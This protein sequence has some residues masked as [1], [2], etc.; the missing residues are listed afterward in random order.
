MSELNTENGVCGTSLDFEL[1]RKSPLVSLAPVSG[2]LLKRFGRAEGGNIAMMFSLMSVVVVSMVGAA[3]DYGR[4]LHAR[5]QTQTALDSAVLAAGRTLQTTYGNATQSLEA[6][7]SYYAQMKSKIA[8]NDTVTFISTKANT[9]IEANGNAY[10]KTPFLSIIG[11]NELPLLYIADAKHS[12]ATIAQ[13]GNNGSSVEIGLMLDTTGSMSGQK[14]IDMK[15]AAK[16]LVDIVIWEDQSK[17]TSRIALAPFANT[18]NVGDYF[19]AVTGQNPNLVTH[20]EQQQTGTTNTYTY[21]PNCY[22]NSGNLKNSCK[23]K[24]QYITGT[25]PIYTTVTIVDNT[26]KA[27]CVVERTGA[28]EFTGAVPGAGTWITSWNDAIAT[29]YANRTALASAGA[30]N[31]GDFD[32]ASDAAKT[33]C[34]EASTIV[35]LTSDKTLLK[36]TID[37]FVAD[38]A[39]AGALGSAWAWYLIEPDWG[40][41]FTGSA[42]PESYAKMSQLGASGQ[43]LLQKIAIL[44]TDGA[45]NTHQGVQYGDS[46]TKAV[47]IRA[48]AVSICAGMKA[49]GIKVYTVGFQIGTN[50][51]IVNTLSSCATDSTYF[52]NASNG[53]GLR[54]A[55]RDIALKISNLRLSH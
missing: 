8:F 12:E 55:F 35:P 27:K 31:T 29:A 51:D 53:D 42:K 32:S 24:P 25:T 4:W 48:K 10:I 38:K 34:P 19:Q 30:S 43:P 36:N 1:N 46:S 20:T 18:V 52:Y 15:L 45:Y 44:M 41:I 37:G 14:L 7:N 54:T 28:Q 17:F 49:K 16:D 13:G 40:T 9:T 21:P 50:T 33:V 39:T 22:N 6:A 2:C 26:A 5:H 47:A 3:V 23:N 11:I